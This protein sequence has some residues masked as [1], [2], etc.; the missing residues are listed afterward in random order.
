VTSSYQLSPMKRISHA[1]FTE[2][3]VVVLRQGSPNFC[4]W[5]ALVF[6]STVG[7]PDLKKVV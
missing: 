3:G 5:A 6:P 2:Y 1:F 7:G 4:L